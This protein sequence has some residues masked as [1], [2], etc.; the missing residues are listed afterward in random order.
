M[1]IMNK[2][3]NNIMNIINLNIIKTNGQISVSASLPSCSGWFYLEHDENHIKQVHPG[4]PRLSVC[5][6]VCG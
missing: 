2:G 5:V 3:M 6:C 1:F 4:V